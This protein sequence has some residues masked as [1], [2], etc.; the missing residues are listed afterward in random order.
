MGLLNSLFRAGSAR[1]NEDHGTWLQP[2]A[3]VLGGR[4][5]QPEHD[6]EHGFIDGADAAI[7]WTLRVLARK[8]HDFQSPRACHHLL[9]HT[10]SV[11]MDEIA[12]V[13][14]NAGDAAGLWGAVD[15]GPMMTFVE[16]ANPLALPAALPWQP[17]GRS[18]WPTGRST[19]RTSAART[20]TTLAR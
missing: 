11:R 20:T 12:V 3:N 13:F 18:S 15:G 17:E 19:R 9:W 6:G 14:G 5:R 8:E 16:R 10:D 4:I 7:S 2:Y 1:P